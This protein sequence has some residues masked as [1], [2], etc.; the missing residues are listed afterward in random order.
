MS[1][2][3][4]LGEGN[5]AVVSDT[6]NM[7]QHDIGTCLGLCIADNGSLN[8]SVKEPSNIKV[9]A[10]PTNWR[11][12]DCIFASRLALSMVER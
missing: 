7:P 8:L 1:F 3:V 2:H 9:P 5:I 4:D 12:D 6:S 10:C 11:G